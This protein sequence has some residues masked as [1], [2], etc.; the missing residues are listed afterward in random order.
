MKGEIEYIADGQIFHG[1]I[2]HVMGTRLEMLAVGICEEAAMQLWEGLHDMVSGLDLMLNRFEPTSEVSQLNMHDDPLGHQ[3]SEELAHMVAMAKEYQARTGGLFDIK[4]KD[5]KLDFGG[6]A[7]GYFLKKCGEALRQA[8]VECAF[9]DFG[10][11]SILGIGHH[12]YGECWKVGVV[13]PFTG[14]TIKDVELVDEAMSTSGNTPYYSGHIRNP[15][16]GETCSD[17]R[18][19]TVVSND[20]LDVEILSTALMIADADDYEKIR[21]EFPSATWEEFRL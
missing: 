3:M 12:P 8:G 7:K 16:T 21:N 19:V 6:F 2:D 5:G 11:S 10:G 4:D 20:A 13:N 1:K 18:I 17:R 14:K 9:V 15:R